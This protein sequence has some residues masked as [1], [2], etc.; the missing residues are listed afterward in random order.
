MAKA[1][2][3]AR[4]VPMWRLSHP[5]REPAPVKVSYRCRDAAGHTREIA[6]TPVLWDA[7]TL[8]R[9]RAWSEWM[10]DGEMF[11]RSSPESAGL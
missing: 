3:G 5:E 11:T 8:Q 7:R 2:R 10:W 1:K 9:H 4:H 6:T